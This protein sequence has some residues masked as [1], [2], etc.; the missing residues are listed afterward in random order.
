MRK[1]IFLLFCCLLS[2][3]PQIQAGT[4]TP[5]HNLYK[6][7]YK[8]GIST[9][10]SKVNRNWDTVDKYLATVSANGYASLNAAVADN[11]NTTLLITNPVILTANLTIPDGIGIEVRHGGYIDLNG[12]TISFPN[13]TSL[14]AGNYKVFHNVTTNAITLNPGIM[15][16]A[17]WFNAILDG[18]T[19]DSTAIQAAVNSTAFITF[20]GMA[21]IS[22]TTITIPATCPGIYGNDYTNTGIIYEGTGRALTMDATVAHERQVYRDF[23]LKLMTSGATGMY[24]QTANHQLIDHVYFN[25]TQPDQK[26]LV[27]DSSRS[28]YGASPYG[29]W[30][31][32]ITNCIFRHTG[33]DKSKVYP[34]TLTGGIQMT[35]SNIS[36]P[37]AT[38]TIGRKIT[39]SFNGATATVQNHSGSVLYAVL[40]ADGIFQDGEVI[41]EEISGITA[42][43]NVTARSRGYGAPNATT[44]SNCEFHTIQ[45]GIRNF[46]GDSIYIENNWYEDYLGFGNIICG[47]TTKITGCRYENSAVKTKL[48]C[49]SSTGIPQVNKTA[50]FQTSGTTGKVAYYQGKFNVLYLHSLSNTNA[51]TKTITNISYSE[52]TVTATIVNNGFS[53]G[54]IVEISGANE[55][56][57]NGTFTISNVTTDT[58][59]YTVDIDIDTSATGTV[60]ATKYPFQAGETV[61]V[62]NDSGNVD[63]VVSTIKNKNELPTI[64]ESMVKGGTESFMLNGIGGEIFSPTSYTIRSNANTSGPCVVNSDVSATVKSRGIT[65]GVVDEPNSRF[66]IGWDGVLKWGS[67]ATM[68]D[69]FTAIARITTTNTTPTCLWSKKM[70][71]TKPCLVTATVF[72]SETGASSSNA[73]FKADCVAKTNN[74]YYQT[75]TA[76]VYRYDPGLNVSFGLSDGSSQSVTSIT[77]SGSTATATVTGHGWNN[78]DFVEFAGANQTE[79]NGK[80]VIANVTTNTFDYTVTGTPTTPATGT[81]TAALKPHEVTGTDGNIYTCSL[82]HAATAARQPVVGLEWRNYWT[83]SGSIGGV[84]S[85]TQPYYRSTDTINLLVTGI[86]GK[87]L[88][89]IAMLNYVYN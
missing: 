56:V 64:F 47:D 58:F 48:V 8:E 15:A 45:D 50:T 11:A 85:S 59:D 81:I 42:T 21:N 44:I 69:T 23:Q 35:L 87:T 65:V 39:G 9:W 86:N 68:L 13:K 7:D 78:G 46:S 49:V 25:S 38:F 2:F 36:P 88:D 52:K 70:K 77:R 63:L 40:G 57:Y 89:W 1:N 33:N 3:I 10:Y 27:I 4:Y 73:L 43:V 34:I 80:Y 24:L 74:I 29:A 17:K 14:S 37:A 16:Y 82:S 55:D 51:V 79:Y 67:G 19:D 71:S 60:T 18:S 62:A 26:L 84:W 32:T 83:K 22:T 75:G 41:T 30:W 61:R 76:T 54:D 28:S 66:S 72:E 20:T 6:L 5:N 53:D 31:N 12:Y